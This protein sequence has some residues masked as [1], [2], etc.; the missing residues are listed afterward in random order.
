MSV[1]EPVPGGGVGRAHGIGEP[2]LALTLPL[3][4][5]DPEHADLVPE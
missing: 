2:Y 1:T 5:P 4:V 3:T